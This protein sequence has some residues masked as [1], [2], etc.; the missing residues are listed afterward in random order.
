ML[1]DLARDNAEAA[2]YMRSTLGFGT[3]AGPSCVLPVSL[4]LKQR[5]SAR[6]AG[7]LLQRAPGRPG[8]LARVLPRLLL[9]YDMHIPVI[10]LSYYLGQ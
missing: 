10:Y 2:M 1:T 9:T 6:G 3:L 5:R 8:G 7:V 4:L